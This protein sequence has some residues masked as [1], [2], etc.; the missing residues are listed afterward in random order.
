MHW[1]KSTGVPFEADEFKAKVQDKEITCP[2]CV[3]PF[4]HPWEKDGTGYGEL[5]F[6]AECTSCKETVNHDRLCTAI[7]LKEMEAIQNS[8][9]AHIS[10]VA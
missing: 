4:L 6:T 9:T 8:D 7:F 10:Y 2:S 1:E 3:V 5:G